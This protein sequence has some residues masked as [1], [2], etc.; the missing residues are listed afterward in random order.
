MPA[1]AAEIEATEALQIVALHNEMLELLGWIDPAIA[2]WVQRRSRV[3]PQL[4]QRP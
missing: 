1:F 2:S 3:P 4:T